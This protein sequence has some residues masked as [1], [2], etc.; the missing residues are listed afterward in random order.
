MNISSLKQLLK[1]YDNEIKQLANEIGKY[2]TNH[3]IDHIFAIPI[4]DHFIKF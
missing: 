1:S 2:N 4:F 3:N